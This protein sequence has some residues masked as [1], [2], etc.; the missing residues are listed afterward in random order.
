MLRSCT[1]CICAFLVVIPQFISGDII[2]SVKISSSEAETYYKNV[3]TENG[4]L[5][6]RL[7]KEMSFANSAIFR[8]L[9]VGDMQKLEMCIE[10]KIVNGEVNATF[11]IFE[12]LGTTKVVEVANELSY[13]RNNGSSTIK[14]WLSTVNDRL[15]TRIKNRECPAVITSPRTILNKGNIPD[16][17]HRILAALEMA[18]V[19]ESIELPT[20]DLS[21]SPLKFSLFNFL[22]FIDRFRNNP[23]GTIALM[24]A[25]KK[26]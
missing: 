24:K 7:P 14:K 6:S 3:E 8:Y 2:P 16:G 17:N 19:G 12:L 23:K 22:V 15:K 11:E 9:A 21:F 10:P 20:Y 25:R 5:F 4:V 18:M 1:K 26:M 13:L